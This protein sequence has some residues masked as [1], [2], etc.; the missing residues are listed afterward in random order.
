M[1]VFVKHFLFHSFFVT[2]ALDS[3]AVSLSQSACFRCTFFFC[4]SILR[5]HCI[6]VMRWLANTDVTFFFYSHLLA[7]ARR[8]SCDFIC[9]RTSAYFVVVAQFSL[10]FPRIAC[11]FFSSPYF[12]HKS[13][14]NAVATSFLPF[15]FFFLV[16]VVCLS[17]PPVP[18]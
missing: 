11:I 6:T 10:V 4:F 2:F 18:S 15:T 8:F 3:F 13:C 9:P 14:V 5:E 17:L 16:S 7:L 12:T 1:C